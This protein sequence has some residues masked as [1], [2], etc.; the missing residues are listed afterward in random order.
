M[1]AL[2]I[3]ATIF[4]LFVLVKMVVVLIDPQ[5]WMKKV[6]EPLLGNP[7]LATTV[8]GVLAIVVGYYVF[9]SLHIV[10]V[11]AVMLFTAL[12]MGV[13]M[14]PYSKAL[15]RIAEEMSATRSELLR[16]AWLPI[17]IWT[18]IALWVLTSVLA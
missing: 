16:N 18:V 3:I 7:R 4:A 1:T 14:M 2:E 9:A 12:V 15:L 5:I 8:Y 6:A 11:A 10:D 17:V 13:G